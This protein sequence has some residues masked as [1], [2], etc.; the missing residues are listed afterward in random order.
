MLNF[1]LRRKSGESPSA[2]PMTKIV[3]ATDWSRQR[4]RCRAKAALSIL[5]PRS[6]SATR[7]G[8]IGNCSRNRGGFLGHSG[9]GVAG[10]AFGNFMNVEAAKAEFAADIVELLAIALGTVP[11][12]GPAL[13][14]RLK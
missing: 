12:P 9:G 6:S 4:P 3:L 5:S 2:P 11:A 14:G 13:T 10:A 1:A 7:T 8:F